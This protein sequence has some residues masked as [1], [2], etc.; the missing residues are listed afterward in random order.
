MES[1]VGKDIDQFL[2]NFA[3]LTPRER[4]ICERIKSGLTSK[5]IASALNI[6][7]LTVHKHRDAIRRKLQLKHKEL[8]LTSYLRSR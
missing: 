6:D 2:N 3:K 5:Q 4:D 7:V 8:N 1:I